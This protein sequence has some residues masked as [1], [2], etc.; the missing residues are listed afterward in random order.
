MPQQGSSK[1]TKKP[2]ASLRLQNSALGANFE[3]FLPHGW[4]ITKASDA[5]KR[6]AKKLRKVLRR[7]R[8][9]R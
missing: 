5:Q 4:Q 1:R 8:R 3:I 2:T 7:K 6:R 9:K